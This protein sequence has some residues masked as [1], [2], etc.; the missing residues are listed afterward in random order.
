MKG[1]ELYDLAKIPIVGTSNSHL[2]LKLYL[3]NLATHSTKL[4]WLTPTLY[5]PMEG[6]P[7]SPRIGP[8][9]RR[10]IGA[11]TVLSRQPRPEIL[12]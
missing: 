9:Q 1:L 8:R 11:S 4:M 10:N 12:L 6:F 5:V 7:D 3:D 2:I